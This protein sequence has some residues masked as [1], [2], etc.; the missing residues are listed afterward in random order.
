MRESYIYYRGK[1]FAVLNVPRRSPLV[2]LTKIGWKQGKPLGSGCFAVCSG[3][4]VLRQLLFWTGTFMFPLG[5]CIAGIN[6]S[7]ITVK[8]L[9]L[10]LSLSAP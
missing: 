7:P 10:N 3:V 2:F 1:I 5:H 9:K 4:E 8:K 6:Y